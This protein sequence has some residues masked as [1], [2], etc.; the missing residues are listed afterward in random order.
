MC[1]YSRCSWNG[2]IISWAIYGNVSDIALVFQRVYGKLK[3]KWEILCNPIH[4]IWKVGTPLL[5]ANDTP[6]W[7]TLF[8]VSQRD[9]EWAVHWGS[10]AGP[11]ACKADRVS[12]AL[13]FSHYSLSPQKPPSAA[14]WKITAQFVPGHLTR[15]TTMNRSTYKDQAIPRVFE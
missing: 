6:R 8:H 2:A 7:G 11:H 15:L 5:S 10:Y 9:G 12:Q 13:N 4:E 3:K 14:L 1:L